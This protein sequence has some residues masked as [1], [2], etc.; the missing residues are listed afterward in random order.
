MSIEQPPIYYFTNIDFNS[1]FYDTEAF[2]ETQANAL[3]LRKRTPD[4]ATALET[5]NAG[6]LSG[7]INPITSSS[8]LNIGTTTVAGNINIGT[9]AVRGGDINIGDGTNPS[10]NI[11]IN[12]G[13]TNGTNT[14]INTGATT[15]GQVNLMTGSATGFVNIA[16]GSGSARVNIGSGTTTGLIT[17]GNTANITSIFGAVRMPSLQAS[18]YISRRG[19]LTQNIGTG[20]SDTIV[21]FPLLLSPSDASLVYNGATGVFTNSSNRQLTLMVSYTVSFSNASTVGQRNVKINNSTTSPQV[22]YNIVDAA[23]S[24]F[25][26]ITGSAT[27]VLLHTQA[28][29]IQCF[30]N[31]GISLPLDTTYTTIQ[32]L[33]F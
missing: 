15:S 27:F 17:I 9:G 11:D 20:G 16:S 19:N 3:Y 5:F 26:S 6:I 1:S 29:N 13:S 30:Q 12:S 25:T 21:L 22:A 18:N 28:F 7:S 4:T 14:N 8:T 2:T 10:G 23:T 31:S 33:M 32:V 24:G